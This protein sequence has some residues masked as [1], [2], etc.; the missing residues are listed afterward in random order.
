MHT[1]TLKVL[2][3]SIPQC[4]KTPTQPQTLLPL[5]GSTGHVAVVAVGSSL[6]IGQ[7]YKATTR[8]RRKC[9]HLTIIHGRNTADGILND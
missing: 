6:Q 8:D 5:Q 1:N 9:Q 4:T 7:I 3:I 2:V